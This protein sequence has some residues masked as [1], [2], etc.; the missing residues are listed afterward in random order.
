MDGREGRGRFEVELGPGSHAGVVRS[1]R[2][3][4][5]AATAAEWDAAWAA[6]PHATYFHSRAWSEDWAAY[7]SGEMRPEPLLVA[8]ADGRR[9]VLPLTRQRRHAG[10]TSRYLLSP[11]G[12]YGGWLGAE[13]LDPE[14][15]MALLSWMG[16]ARAPF[17][18][19]VN[20]F[21]PSAET[22][23]AEASLEDVTHVLRLHWGPESACERASH[24]HACAVRKAWRHGVSVRVAASPDDWAA[25]YAIYEASLAR[26][27]ARASSRYGTALF[28]AL[29]RRGTPGVE[30]WLAELDDGLIVAGGLCL[31]GPRHASYWH[32][33]ALAEFFE[34]RPANLLVHELMIDAC[35]RS[36]EWFDL[37]PSGGHAGVRT[38]KERVGAVAV[39]SPVIVRDRASAPLRHWGAAI[40]GFSRGG[41]AQAS[42]GSL[43]R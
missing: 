29:R 35:L 16:K 8:F 21:D 30:L 23:A 25:Y 1:S 27:G 12:T 15:A 34:L 10:F 39:P 18:W 31:Y 11:A 28:E 2:L 40:H 24:G 9:V 4:V 36:L 5:R 42:K 7:T 38:F 6:C 41:S 22:L 32:A 26:W 43:K 14:Q 13:P 37:N 3:E 19:R 20:P 33:A 17:W